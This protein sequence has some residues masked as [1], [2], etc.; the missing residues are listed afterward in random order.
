VTAQSEFN[1]ILTR[2]R[3]D[4]TTLSEIARALGSTAI[5]AMKAGNVKLPGDQPGYSDSGVG[6]G[7]GSIGGTVSDPPPSLAPPRRPDEPLPALTDIAEIDATLDTEFPE[8]T[9]P[10]FRYQPIADLA[11]FDEPLPDVNGSVSLPPFPDVSGDLP[12]LPQPGGAGGLPALDLR[13][14]APRFA[15]PPEVAGFNPETFADALRRYMALVMG[16]IEP[17][18]RSVA[19]AATADIERILDDLLG[20]TDFPDARTLADR[21][22]AL[23]LELDTWVESAVTGSRSGQPLPPAVREAMRQSAAHWAETVGRDVESRLSSRKIELREALR[24]ALRDILTDLRN[25][26]ASIRLRMAEQTLT[27]HRFAGRYAKRVTSAILK[28]FEAGNFDAYDLELAKTSI[29]LDVAESDLL[30]GTLDYT[31]TKARQKVAESEQDRDA[32]AVE[33]LEA[34]SERQQQAVSVYAAKVAGLRAERR[35]QRLPWELYFKR[36]QL[37]DAQ[38]SADDAAYRVAIAQASGNAA[39]LEGASAELA[40]HRAK[41]KAFE[42]EIAAFEAATDARITANESILDEFNA[43]VQIA[44]GDAEMD[45]MDDK[46]RLAQYEAEANVFMQDARLDQE[47]LRAEIEHEDGTTKLETA[48]QEANRQLMLDLAELQLEQDKA[49]ADTSA[50]S[51]RLLGN[52]AEAAASAWNGLAYVAQEKLS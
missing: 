35:A 32:L 2:A 27:A 28:A 31:L 33:R 10:D 51:A 41:Q 21:L 11:R 37:L 5:Q 18:A 36:V 6:G 25:G 12:D 48:V 14:T 29:A 47:R 7:S 46:L 26:L 43:K 30:I 24:Q 50:D 20:A 42:A 52:M 17:A 4:T 49:I 45:I 40:A 9:L 1:A 8:L 22:A 15:L 16:D 13:V 39:L 23:R 34:E 19:D 44:L 38:A 3:T